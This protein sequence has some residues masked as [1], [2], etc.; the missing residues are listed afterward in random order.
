MSGPPWIVCQIGAREHYA[1]ARA[2]HREG[3]L[4]QLITD[5][6]VTPGSLL[7][8][9]PGGLGRKLRSRYDSDLAAAPVAHFTS[10]M[11]HLEAAD[12]LPRHRDRWR[13]IMRRN[14]LFQ[15]RA[16]GY[17]QSRGLLASGSGGRPVV[18]AYAYAAKAIFEA[19]RAAGARTILGQ[20]DGGY[21]EQQL[22]LKV[23][24]QRRIGSEYHSAPPD[25]YW[26]DWFRECH[27]ADRVIVNS[28]WSHHLLVKAGVSAEKLEI[29]PLIYESSRNREAEKLYP[30]LFTRERKLRVLFLGT[31][32]ARKG[33]FEAIDCARVLNREPVEFVFAGPD[34]EGLA[35]SVAGMKNTRWLPPVLRKDVGLLYRWADVFL[36]PTHS[37]GFGLT[38]LEAFD[39]GL[40]VLASKNCARVVQHGINGFLLESVSAPEMADLLRRL[41]RAPELLSRLSSATRNG[42]ASYTNSVVL[43]MLLS[44]SKGIT[45][46][47]EAAHAP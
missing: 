20:I 24:Q 27:L 6:W 34:L 29:V 33:I 46:H 32:V 12:R 40:P 37:D 39:W 15:S 35:G 41:I 16:S 13:T 18:F 23:C 44:A 30:D 11:L 47:T 26:S 8:R 42:L 2:L 21:C 31:L 1:L 28:A 45:T 3:L 38:Q 5:S 43:P 25:E 7:A 14:Q 4:R 9:L 22:V 36:F 17:L 19:A 10:S